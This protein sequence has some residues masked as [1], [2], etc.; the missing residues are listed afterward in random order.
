MSDSSVQWGDVGLM[1]SSVKRVRER[2]AALAAAG[3]P[4][5]EAVMAQEVWEAFKAEHLAKHSHREGRALTG[6]EVLGVR[7]R[8]ME[9]T[10][11]CALRHDHGVEFEPEYVK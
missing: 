6:A 4:A 5:F 3:T 11:G 1:K 7:V 2:I 10:R 8:V 9:G